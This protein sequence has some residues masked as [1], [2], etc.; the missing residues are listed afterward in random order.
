MRAPSPVPL[1]DPA[2]EI[3]PTA[4][5]TLRGANYWAARPVTRLDLAVGAYDAI[6]SA[7]APSVTGQ[8]VAAMPGLVEHHCSPGV[9]GGFLERLRTGTYAPHIVEH[10]ALELQTLVGHDTGFGQTRDGDRGGEYTLVFE[11]RHAAVGLRAA[12]L[13]LEVVQ[14]A[15]AGT[16]D[17][18]RHE[19]AELRALAT[20]ADLPPLERRIACAITGG[21]ARRAA[22]DALVERGVAAEEL[23]ELTPASLLWAGLPYAASAAAVILDAEPCDVPERYRDPERAAAL[24]S[25]VADGVERDGTLV[26]P[27]GVP[28]LRVRAL[29]CGRRLAL[30]STTGAVPAADARVA[31]AVAVVE[32]GRVVLVR[33]GS[34]VDAGA[35]DAS[36]PAAA[37]LA[38]ALAASA[39]ERAPTRVE[40]WDVTKSDV[41]AST[42]CAGE[43]DAGERTLPAPTRSPAPR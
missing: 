4:L 10:V 38:A 17:G 28:A 9:R 23:V 18:V 37:Q 24:V 3:R 35:L 13:A 41:G 36:R 19:V 30:F 21:G 31:D 15:F 26:L 11:H 43:A 29:R 34:R 39:L 40:A 1:P 25:V 27:A 12:V 8:L 14:R 20:T 42:A 32:R 5:L 33:G 16:L 6:S 2:V 7:Q 22:R